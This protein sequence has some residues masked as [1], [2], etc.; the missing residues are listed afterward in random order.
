MVGFLML[1]WG[2]ATSQAQT[3]E[4]V[5]LCDPQLG[6]GEYEE[7]KKSF[8]R[9]VQKINQLK[10]D[11]VVICGDLVHHA[12]D[13]S[14]QH[15]LSIRNKLD[16]PV[17]QVPGN[18]DIG[19]NPT[20]ESLA[21]YRSLFGDDYFIKEHKGISFIFTN[22][23]LWKSYTEQASEKHHQWFEQTMDSLY[24]NNIPSIVVGHYPLFVNESQEKDEYFNLPLNY[25]Q[26]ILELMVRNKTLAYLSGHKHLLV[27]NT[28]E[29]IQLLSGESTSVNFDKRPLGFRVWSVS[30][31][32][33]THRFVPLKEY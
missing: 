28:Y 18:H 15:Y 6:M 14:F 25:R 20:V 24:N 12:S 3:F 22:T 11:F 4:F 8:E 5:Q 1:I 29:G 13:S 17:Y 7:D 27:T 16:V 19:L 33:I 21:N 2:Y 23:Q 10:P 9:A 31:Q 26:K 32:D 30:S